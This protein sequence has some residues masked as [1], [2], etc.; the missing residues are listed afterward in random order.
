MERSMAMFISARLPLL[1]LH[2]EYIRE[3]YRELFS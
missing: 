1:G 3:K 2:Q